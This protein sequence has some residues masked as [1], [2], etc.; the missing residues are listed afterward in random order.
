MC[1][2]FGVCGKAVSSQQTLA[3]HPALLAE[4]GE[5]VALK[6][7][8]I[9]CLPDEK[10]FTALSLSAD[11]LKAASGGLLGQPSHR[12]VELEQQGRRQFQKKF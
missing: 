10:S 5:A 3:C 4:D 12:L 1:H 8:S 7:T 6:T 11:S 2:C 9:A